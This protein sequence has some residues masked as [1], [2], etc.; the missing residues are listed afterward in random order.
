MASSIIL[1]VLG[2]IKIWLWLSLFPVFHHQHLMNEY[3]ALNI[4]VSINY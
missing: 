4:L 3:I 2:F 1:P